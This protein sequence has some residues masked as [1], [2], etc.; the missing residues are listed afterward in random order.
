MSSHVTDLNHRFAIDNAVQFAEGAGGLTKAVL[1][2]MGSTV[3]V[4]LLG[5]TVTRFARPDVGEIIFVSANSPFAEGKAIRGGVPVCFPW[6]GP[7]PRDPKLPAHGFVRTQPWTVESAEVN[8]DSSVTLTLAFASSDAT[9]AMWPHDFVARYRITVGK[10]LDMAMAVTNTGSSDL[11]YELAL[12]TY[13]TCSDV[14]T[15]R[16]EGLDGIIFIDKVD[17][18]T[19]KRQNGMIDIRGETD[20]VYLGT[21]G[22]CILHD[23]KA[24]PTVVSKDGSHATVVWNP[25]PVKAEAMADLKGNQW[26]GFVCIETANC[27]DFSLELAPGETHVT[28][29]VISRGQGVPKLGP[30]AVIDKPGDNS[31]EDA[32]A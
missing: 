27:F 8:G 7:N 6:F 18:M 3:E 31:L 12:H 10:S 11:R 1:T 13:L 19:R 26:P 30:A 5:A 23:T 14:S 4:Y 24:A 17:Q 21:T 15:I 25:G 16:I 2:A 22:A 32:K 20:R 29:A 28:R 9:R